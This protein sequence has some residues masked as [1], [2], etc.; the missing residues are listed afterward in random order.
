MQQLDGTTPLHSAAPADAGTINK[1]LR[2]IGEEFRHMLA[3]AIFF[4]IGFNLVVSSMNLILSEYFVS[5]GN[6]MLA[7]A[8]ALVV[9]K[10]VLVADAMPMLRRFDA[11]P[12]IQP[13]LFK[14]FAYWLFVFIARLLEAAV[15]YLFRTGHITGFADFVLEQFSW[16]KFLFIQIWILVLFLLYTTV[17]EFNTLFGNGELF[18]IFFRYRSSELKLARRQQ[19]RTLVQVGRL[20]ER[21]TAEELR[22]PASDVH[23]RLV[24][25]LLE[26]AAKRKPGTT[27]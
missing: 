9:G 26:L 10:A 17:Q 22:D 6:F 18:R 14:T 15:E 16:H 11:A 13:I 7:T 19:V 8:A 3:P 27:G 24:A 4:A 25:L 2:K 23:R 12:L 1:V 20:T 21:H 5:F